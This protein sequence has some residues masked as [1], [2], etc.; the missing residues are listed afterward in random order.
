MHRI[1]HVRVRAGATVLSLAASVALSLGVAPRTVQAQD[2]NPY[3]RPDAWLCKPGRTDVC[4]TPVT[5]TTL[6]AA[7]KLAREEIA[8]N[9]AAPVDCFYIYPTISTD[10]NGNSSLVAGPG[11]RRAVANQLS[12]FGSVCRPFAPMYRQVTLAGLRAAMNG[13][14]AAVDP[15]LAY[16]D[17]AAAWKYYLENENQGRG[18]VLIGHSQGTRMLMQLIQQEIEGKPVQA[19]I[20]SAILPGFNIEVAPGS[21]KGGALRSMPLCASKNDTGCAVAYA[22]FR[23]NSPPPDNARFGRNRTPGKEIACV[24]PVALSGIALSS[25]ITTRSNLLGSEAAAKDW[26]TMRSQVDTTFIDLPGLVST[27][28]VKEGPLSYLAATF[29]PDSDAKRPQDI[30]GDIVVDGRT[31]NDWGLHLIDINLVAGNL[32]EIVRNQSAAYLKR[33]GK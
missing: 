3:A 2:S 31:W 13:N 21:D 24:D 17:V 11:E 26:Q 20:V 4:S 25:F 32:I 14:P 19:R 29:S 15:A 7:G 8:A 28:C 9:P 16:S 30:P 6:N 33:A 18:V 10:P 1:H 12:M 5:R 23:S 22:T 27:R